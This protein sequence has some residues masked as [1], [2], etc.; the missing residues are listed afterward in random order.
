MF[1]LF[2]LVFGLLSLRAQ[3]V[4]SRQFKLKFPNGVQQCE[5]VSVSFVAGNADQRIVSPMTLTVLPFNST[6]IFV[7]IPNTAATP[8]GVYV[9]FLPLAA[10]TNFVA[11]LDDASPGNIARVSDVIKVLPS[12]SGNDTCLPPAT[13]DEPNNTLFQL[14]D[15]LSQCQNLTVNYNTTLVDSAPLGG[16]VSSSSACVVSDNDD[17]DFSGTGAVMMGT[18][19]KGSSSGIPRPV[20]IGTSVGGGIVLSLI[21]AMIWF[22][23]RDRRRKREDGIRFDAARL[24]RGEKPPARAVTVFPPVEIPPTLMEGAVANPVYTFERFMTPS[25]SRYPRN[26]LESWSQ[27]VPD[28]QKTPLSKQ[29]SISSIPS[30]MRSRL[31]QQQQDR[32]SERVSINSL[33]IEGM[34]NMATV[35][36]ERLSR[37]TSSTGPSPFSPNLA[38]SPSQFLSVP[39]PALVRVRS[40]PSRGH[41]RSPSDV[42]ADPIASPTLSNFSIDPFSDENVK[43]DNSPILRSFTIRSPLSAIRTASFGLPSSPRSGPRYSSESNISINED[44]GTPRRSSRG[45]GTGDNYGIAR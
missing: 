28:D 1:R 33:D 29:N 43:A 3:V 39:A 45:S 2:A 14:G 10:G 23:F 6:P 41:L 31:R 27:D 30:S 24:E 18:T 25:S 12:P 17:D 15:V 9:T 5:P 34:L 42:P 26:S 22:V 32:A 16:D 40:Y 35:Q 7:P 44:V 8:A 20:V 19:S 11:S 4:L 21:I 36:S 38:L 37:Q 13:E